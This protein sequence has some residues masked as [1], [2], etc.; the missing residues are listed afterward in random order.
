MV[1]LVIGCLM[2]LPAAGT[3]AA[4]AGALIAQAAVTDDDGYFE[5]TFDRI[6]S[7]GVAI[8]ATDIRFDDDFHDAVWIHD[9]MDVD[10]RLRVDGA[11]TTDDVFVGIARSADVDRYLTGARYADLVGLDGRRPE[12]ELVRGRRSIEPPVDQEFWAASAAGGG[13]QELTW[14][15]RA[16]NWSV[17]VM[18][19][20]GSPA[21][22]ADVEVGARSGVLTPIAVTL[23][24]LGGIGLLTAVVLIVVGA[25]RPRSA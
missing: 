7:D 5:F 16:G 15:A 9:W 14:D 4:G 8:A 21:V 10:V 25:R 18:N 11:R 6:Q 13:V 3:I 17:V 12:Y 1:A 2:L 20:D 23:V 22:A 19:A 24:V